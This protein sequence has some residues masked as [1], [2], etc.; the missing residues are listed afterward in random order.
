MRIRTFILFLIILLSLPSFQ[1][2]G[3]S[4]F[5]EKQRVTLTV[6]AASSLSKTFTALGSNFEKKHPGVTVLFSFLASSTLAIQINAGAP[7]DVFASASGAEMALAKSRIPH[8]TFFAGNRIVL[9][10]PKG[11]AFHISKLTDLNKAGVKWIQCAYSAPCG[12]AT[13]SALALDGQ[14]KS[15]P[16]SL[17]PKVSSVVAKLISREVDAAFIYH[18]DY[19]AHARDLRE[20]KFKN[21]EF[22]ITRYPIGAVKDSAHLK[23][24]T[25][26]IGLVL[27][28]AGRKVLTDAGFLGVK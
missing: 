6:F 9:A 1:A 20:I 10:T 24:A 22:A 28:P 7:A 2:S 26:F 12:S 3:S 21:S 15:K 8:T 16:V 14:V 11:N 27:S 17:E 18:T 5:Q 23:L 4:N 19:V 13:K 25:E